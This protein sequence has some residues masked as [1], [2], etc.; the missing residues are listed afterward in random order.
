MTC[1]LNVLK[2]P[3]ITH[4]DGTE[5]HGFLDDSEVVVQSQTDMVYR[6]VEGPGT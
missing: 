4:P 3:L 6:L 2:R 5:V 1:K